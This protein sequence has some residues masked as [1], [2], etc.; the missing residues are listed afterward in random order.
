[1]PKGSIAYANLRRALFAVVGRIPPGQVV[2]TAVLGTCLNVPA[3]HVAYIL[4]QIT[5][6][7]A[8]LL[9]WHR[10]I[11]RDG[12]FG[13]EAALSTRQVQQLDLLRREGVRV[14]SERGIL[15]VDAP[16]W[17]PDVDHGHVFWADLDPLESPHSR[18]GA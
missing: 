1:M 5:P 6:D 10:V 7:E 3:R 9:P 8:E 11:P 14:E 4:S 12:R 18:G 15:R 2:E 17:Q 16:A 13:L